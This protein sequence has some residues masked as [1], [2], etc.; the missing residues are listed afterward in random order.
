M[1]LATL[2]PPLSPEQHLPVLLFA[3]T[4]SQW[5]HLQHFYAGANAISVETKPKEGCQLPVASSFS[6]VVRCER[7]AFSQKRIFSGTEFI[8]NRTMVAKLLVTQFRQSC[9]RLEKEY[10]LILFDLM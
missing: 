6:S 1:Q 5:L 3:A 9:N 10:I 7:R 4:V 8:L 2:F